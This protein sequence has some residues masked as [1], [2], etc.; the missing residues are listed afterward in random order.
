MLAHHYFQKLSFLFCGKKSFSHKLV[1]IVEVALAR[2]QK[3]IG[4]V[5][6]IQHIRS[7]AS[8]SH[9][10]RK[11]HDVR[12]GGA[13]RMRCAQKRVRKRRQEE[14]EQTR[15]KSERKEPA[16]PFYCEK[17]GSENSKVE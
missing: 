6:F 11:I 3:L 5:P 14:E 17:N 1:Q 9:R 12:N 15:D 2:F 16:F 7:I 8:D 13:E 10:S 4:P